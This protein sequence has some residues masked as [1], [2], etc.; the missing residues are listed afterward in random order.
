MIRKT[1]LTLI[2][3]GYLYAFIRIYKCLQK[4][5]G[6]QKKKKRKKS[7]ILCTSIMHVTMK[8]SIYLDFI[9]FQYMY[10]EEFDFA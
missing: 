5:L 4:T 7:G 9:S 6:M 8:E 10:S 3:L 2:E 1:V